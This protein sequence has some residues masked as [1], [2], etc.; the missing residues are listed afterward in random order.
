MVDQLSFTIAEVAARL[1]VS[2]MTIYRLVHSEVLG[3]YR[4]GRSFRI[5][6]VQLLEYMRA[7]GALPPEPPDLAQ[8]MREHLQQPTGPPEPRDLRWDGENLRSKPNPGNMHLDSSLA[9]PGDD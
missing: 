3:A 7:I 8:I 2:K 9:D 6:S 4:V 5:S 1:R